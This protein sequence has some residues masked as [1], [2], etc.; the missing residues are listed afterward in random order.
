MKVLVKYKYAFFFLICIYFK[1]I[2]YEENHYKIYRELLLEKSI[3]YSKENSIF[4][5]DSYIG[6]EIKKSISIIISSNKKKIEVLCLIKK[7]YRN[8]ISY[9]PVLKN[10]LFFFIDPIIFI[11]ILIL[12]IKKR[13]KKF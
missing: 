1:Q 11:G 12:F 3:L 9:Y 8:I 6:I 10:N 4:Y 7:K 13:I 5:T 2:F